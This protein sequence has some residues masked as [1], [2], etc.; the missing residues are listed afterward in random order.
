MSSSRAATPAGRTRKTTRTRGTATKPKPKAAPKPNAKA[1]TKPKAKPKAKTRTTA[2]PKTTTRPKPKARRAAAKRAPRKRTAPKRAAPRRSPLAWA[3]DQ[4]SGISWR[5]RLATIA[6]LAVTAAA[7]YF[8]WARDSSLVAIDNVDV[9]GVTA[10]DRSQIIG[11]LTDASES[12]TTLHVDRAKLESIAAQFPTVASINIDPNFPHGMRIEVTE[13][14]PTMIVAAGG[15]Q[16]PVAADGT[17]LTGVE[18]SEDDHLPVLE[19][20]KAPAGATL[21]GTELDEALVA[22]AAP[23]ELRPLISKL[24]FTKE[25]GVQIT[26]RGGIPVRFGTGAAAGEKWSAVAAVLAD[27]KLTTLSYV[28]VRVPERPAVGGANTGTISTDPQL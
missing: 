3:R 17:L 18:V 24:E 7:G 13:R 1:T 16:V 26:L 19:V 25:F 23:P 6:I 14:P 9:V 28:D 10:G 2:R 11:Q 5:Y 12:M 22:G 20:E 8:F 21:Q 15:R 27:P 4:I